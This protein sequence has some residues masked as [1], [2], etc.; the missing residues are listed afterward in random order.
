MLTTHT[1]VTHMP[2]KII[3]GAVIDVTRRYSREN[4]EYYYIIDILD[5]Q[6]DARYHTYA[7]AS[8]RNYERW[9]TV[10]EQ[11]NRVHW[12]DDIRVKHQQ[13]GLLNADTG[14]VTSFDNRDDFAQWL[15]DTGRI[16]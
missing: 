8:N 13:K 2:S 3:S 5:P 9:Q 1:G 4:D 6:E 11:P 14:D 12:V 15:T 7:S 16:K 10:V